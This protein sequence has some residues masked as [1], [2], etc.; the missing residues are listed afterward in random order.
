MSLRWVMGMM[1][2]AVFS[3]V[4][5]LAPA[6]ILSVGFVLYHYYPWSKLSLLY[7]APLFISILFPSTPSPTFVGWLSPML[8][9]F[10]YERI[11]ETTKVDTRAEILSGRCNYIL[12]AQP[13]G[14]VSLLDVS[15]HHTLN[16]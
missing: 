14:V 1:M 16:I 11:T 6:Y 9:Y 8:D 13:H 2:A 12:A 15:L 10:D 7:V 3:L 5:I 4:Y